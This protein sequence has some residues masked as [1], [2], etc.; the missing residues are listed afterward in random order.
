MA[1][2]AEVSIRIVGLTQT[3]GVIPLGSGAL[4]LIGIRFKNLTRCVRAEHKRR[5]R[6]LLALK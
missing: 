3:T 2:S 1:L 5:V 6:L 4:Q